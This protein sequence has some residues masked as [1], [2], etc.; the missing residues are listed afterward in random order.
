MLFTKTR[1]C[2]V[3]RLPLQIATKKGKP[4]LPCEEGWCCWTTRR[5]EACILLL[6][7]LQ[8]SRF[9]I[10]PNQHQI[11]HMYV[12]DCKCADLIRIKT[13]KHQ[14][15]ESFCHGASCNDLNG[16][17]S[18]SHIFNLKLQFSWNGSLFSSVVKSRPATLISSTESLFL[19]TEEEEE[20]EMVNLFLAKLAVSILVWAAKDASTLTSRFFSFFLL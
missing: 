14:N 19:L 16:S 10:W 7:S 1:R 2:V 18:I 6:S 9:P 4:T 5:E 17:N 13:N 3:M 20:E 8:T 15:P 12:C 11:I